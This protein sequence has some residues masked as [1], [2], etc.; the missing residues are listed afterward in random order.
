M[1]K[2]KSN[3]GITLIEL[4]VYIMAL[5][6]VVGVLASIRNFFFKNLD[7]VKETARYAASFDKFNSY[8][9]KDVKNNKH[10]NISSDGSTGNLIITFE[11]GT[12][13][14][15]NYQDSGIYRGKVKIAT[16]IS[17]FTATSKTLVINNFEKEI[18]SLNM[19]IGTSNNTL[20]NKSIDYTLKYW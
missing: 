17:A 20:F 4:S 7:I 15:Y 13:Y 12:N 11:D 18:I 1:K 14:V 8:F 16:N 3:K 9:V 5:L 2:L 19:V 6:V 10:V